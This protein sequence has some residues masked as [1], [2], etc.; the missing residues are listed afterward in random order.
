MKL[1]QAANIG[2]L[3]ELARRRLPKMVFDYIDG[4]AGEEITARRNRAALDQVCLTPEPLVDVSKRSLTTTLFGKEVAFPAIVGPT[5]LNGAFWPE[6]DLALARGAAR[7]GVPFVLS[8]A[9]TVRFETLLRAA[10]PLRWFQLYMMKDRGLVDAFLQ[11]V[12]ESGFDVLQLTVDTSVSGRRNRDIRNAFTLPFRWTA[13]NFF[14]SARHPQWSV[15]MLRAGPPMLR[16]FEDIAGAPPR[17][18][19][20]SDVMQEQLS[21]SFT[22]SDLEWLR[23]RWRG[24][25]VIKGISSAEHASRSM[26]AGSDG[27]VV[28]NH[29]GRQL[30]GTRAS[31]EWL[32]QI[33][34]LVA[35]RMTVLVDSGFRS[36]NDIGKAIALGADGVQLGRATLY[37]LAAAGEAGVIHAL[38]IL[39]AELDR[40]MALSGARSISELRG[41]VDGARAASIA[42]PVNAPMSSFSLPTRLAA[43]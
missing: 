8:T 33:V 12:F 18:A 3:R 31:V 2:D 34:D 9:A 16:L 27:V 14:D 41:R 39:K 4:A 43:A 10:G 5:G 29:G 24:R 17:G 7:S 38:S 40:T 23:S 25:L 42:A 1:T 26:D 19:T 20:I 15:S 11:R 21:S 37:G 28:S 22:W 36:G 6:G 13:R 30:D 35:G 32:P